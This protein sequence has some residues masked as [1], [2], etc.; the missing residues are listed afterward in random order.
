MDLGSDI[1]LLQR[2][3]ARWGEARDLLNDSDARREYDLVLERSAAGASADVDALLAADGLVRR[4]EKFLETG[5]FKQ[6]HILLK[7]VLELRPDA[8]HYQFLGAFTSGMQGLESCNE[9]Y[10]RMK[11]LLSKATVPGA[12]RMLGQIALRDSEKDIARRHFK[13]ALAERKDDHIAQRELRRI[14]A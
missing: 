13:A 3:L 14:E 1:E 8:E 7:E 4:A 2:V 12:E 6:A 9:I 11:Q 5:H 10:L